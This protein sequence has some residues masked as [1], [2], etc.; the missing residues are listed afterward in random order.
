MHPCGVQN[1]GSDPAVHALDCYEAHGLIMIFL[2]PASRDL[3]E[4][5]GDGGGQGCKLQGAM[6]TWSAQK[7]GERGPGG[8]GREI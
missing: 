3:R 7:T 6:Q 5:M 2:E 1:R 4:Q 8:A